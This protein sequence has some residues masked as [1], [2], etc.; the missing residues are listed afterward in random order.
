MLTRVTYASSLNSGRFHPVLWLKGKIR[1][2]SR[3]DP[4]AWEGRLDVCSDDM[5]NDR[6]A[7]ALFHSEIGKRVRDSFWRELRALVRDKVPEVT[8]RFP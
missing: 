3:P 4:T 5:I 2:V 8:D 7:D 6:Q 1:S